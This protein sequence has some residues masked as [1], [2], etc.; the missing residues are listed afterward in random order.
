MNYY[1]AT[2]QQIISGTNQWARALRRIVG[3]WITH[4]VVM[5]Y[6]NYVKTT[7]KKCVICKN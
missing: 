2:S 3:E 1:I 7:L 5:M 4:D 6:C